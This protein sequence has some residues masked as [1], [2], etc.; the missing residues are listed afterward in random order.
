[1]KTIAVCILIYLLF[2][3]NTFSFVNFDTW[4]FPLLMSDI[5]WVGVELMSA[6]AVIVLVAAIVA[7]VTLGLIGAVV[8][9]LIGTF[10]AFLF[11]SVVI[12]WPLLLVAV[13]CW[14]VADTKKVAS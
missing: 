12:G 8:V 3:T 11:G 10:L 7:L 14:L 2:F 6:F 1:M 13:L 5:S 9:A 4:Q